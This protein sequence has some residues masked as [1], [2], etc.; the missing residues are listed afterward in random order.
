[1]IHLITMKKANGMIGGMTFAATTRHKRK[2]PEQ[3]ALDDFQKLYG[4][5]GEIVRTVLIP[6]SK[7]EAYELKK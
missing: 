2:T 7:D 4:T 6:E 5:A 3:Q 1:M